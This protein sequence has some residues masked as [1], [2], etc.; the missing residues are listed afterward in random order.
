M[1]L[2][3]DLFGMPQ[4]ADAG[5]LEAEHNGGSVGVLLGRARHSASHCRRHHL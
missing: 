2:Q 5:C 1:A 3:I 4:L